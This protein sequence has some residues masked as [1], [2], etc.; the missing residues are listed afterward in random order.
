[1]TA[2]IGFN[3]FGRSCLG[4]APDRAEAGNQRAD[5]VVQETSRIQPG[6]T[7]RPCGFTALAADN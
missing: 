7:N 6:R 2:R 4:V 1:M 5:K 3:G